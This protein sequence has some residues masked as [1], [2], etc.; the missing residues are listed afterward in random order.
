MVSFGKQA[1]EL[2]MQQREMPLEARPSSMYPE[3]V[4]HSQM[5]AGCLEALPSRA[6]APSLAEIHRH[7]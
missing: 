2:H 5:L 4:P 6:N 1:L 7:L 3:P